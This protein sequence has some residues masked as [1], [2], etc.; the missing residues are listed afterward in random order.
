[1]KLAKKHATAVF[2]LVMVAI[3]ATVMSLVLGYINGA[4]AA[5]FWSV[6]PRQA[7]IAFIVALPAAT[8]ARWVA[9]RVVA[10]V[11]E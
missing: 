3:M 4:F 1:M 10:R 2:L 6:W 8:G 9:V 5:R 11:V 7:A